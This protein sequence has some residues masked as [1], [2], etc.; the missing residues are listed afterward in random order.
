M[1]NAALQKMPAMS[2]K[3]TSRAPR[4]FSASRERASALR[5]FGASTAPMPGCRGGFP[6]AFS[7]IEDGAERPFAKPAGKPEEEVLQAFVAGNRLRPELGHRPLRD[8]A[9]GLNNPDPVA[10]SLRHFQR[11]R[12]HEHGAA[13]RH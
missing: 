8:H 5:H 6:R 7:R 11:V 9:P 12:A 10:H 2:T 1:P 3:S 13:A 4:P